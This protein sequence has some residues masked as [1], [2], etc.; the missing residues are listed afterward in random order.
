MRSDGVT[1]L[2]VIVVLSASPSCGAKE[3]LSSNDAGDD[4]FGLV[5]PDVT[6]PVAD[7]APR[8]QPHAGITLPAMQV[9]VVYVGDEDAGGAPSDDATISSLLGSS[10]W[11]QLGEYGIGNGALVGSTRVASG[12]FFQSGDLDNND[13][14]DV[15]VLQARV[16]QSLHGD[17]DA[18]TTSTVSIPGAQAYV[19]FLPEGVNVDLGQRGNYTY[20]TCVDAFGYHAYDGVEPYAILPPCAEGRSSYAASHELAEMATDPHPYDGWASDLDIPVNGGEV[21]DLCTQQVDA[22]GLTVTWLWSNQANGCIP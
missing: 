16:A 2:V 5:N 10:Y 9:G 22:A 12:A 1:A 8:L 15:L 7:A 21:A 4:R 18:G 17:S 19:F 13:L 14:V 11:L 6:V 20:Q 3:E